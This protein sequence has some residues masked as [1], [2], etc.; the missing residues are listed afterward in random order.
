[1]SFRV[2]TAPSQYT[3]YQ[4]LSAARWTKFGEHLLSLANP[5][6]QATNGQ[7]SS[8]TRPVVHQPSDLCRPVHEQSP[9]YFVKHDVMKQIEEN[10]LPHQSILPYTPSKTV[11]ES[12]PSVAKSAS[13]SPLSQIV[14]VV[15]CQA[16]FSSSSATFESHRS[17][18]QAVR[19]L[20][21]GDRQ[22]PLEAFLD[23]VNEALLLE[24][25]TIQSI[26]DARGEK[27]S[28]VRRPHR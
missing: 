22:L 23:T 11:D 12:L 17:G 10:F 3:E 27:V 4:I 21:S 25:N 26:W 7:D 18:R 9:Y 13:P 1:M 19:L 28:T 24:P 6:R 5:Q 2:E 8:S 14:T 15:Q 20:V 16:S